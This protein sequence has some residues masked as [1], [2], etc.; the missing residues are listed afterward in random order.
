MPFRASDVVKSYY[1]MPFVD[2]ESNIYVDGVVFE[3]MAG[4]MDDDW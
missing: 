1:V 4:G 3:D 2:G